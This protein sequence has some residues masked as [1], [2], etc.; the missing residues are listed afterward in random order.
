MA[1]VGKC[2]VVTR[3]QMT[4]TVSPASIN[5]LVHTGLYIIFSKKKPFKVQCA[6]HTQQHLSRKYMARKE[7]ISK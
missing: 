5:D 7:L 4:V 3:H 2:L 6:A 1:V